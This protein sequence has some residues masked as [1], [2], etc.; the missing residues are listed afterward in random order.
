MPPMAPDYQYPAE[1][2][3][4]PRWPGILLCIALLAWAVI[5][6][7]GTGVVTPADTKPA[8]DARCR[9]QGDGVYRYQQPI[10]PAKP[11]KPL[12]RAWEM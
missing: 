11:T 1:I 5:V 8:C 6:A 10:R 2:W 9:Q 4:A 7:W 12:P 3:P